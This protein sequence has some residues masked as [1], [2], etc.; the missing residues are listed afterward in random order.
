MHYFLADTINSSCS[1]LGQH[2]DNPDP[3][4]SRVLNE[5]LPFEGG[6]E[7]SFTSSDDDRLVENLDL[8]VGDRIDSWA[9]ENLPTSFGDSQTA[10]SFDHGTA[11]PGDLVCY[12]MASTPSC[13]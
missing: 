9:S 1:E 11:D 8:T 2:W 7:Q 12:G 6:E 3:S 10:T 4:W 5:L 13:L